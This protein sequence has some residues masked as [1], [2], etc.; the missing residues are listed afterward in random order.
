ML[1]PLRIAPLAA[2]AFALALAPSHAPEP[3]APDGFQVK[4]ELRPA[5]GAH[6][7]HLR[8]ATPAGEPWSVHVL[9]VRHDAKV[10]IVAMSG[11][12]RNGRMARV[13]PTRIAE[14]VGGAAVV[15][16]DYDLPEPNLG[17][18]DGLSVTSG[19][20]WTTGKPGW[21]AMAILTSGEPAIGYPRVQVTLAVGDEKIEISALNKPFGALWG[22][23]LRLFTREFRDRL[24][25]PAP[26]RAVVIENLSPAL[27]LRVDSTVRGRIRRVVTSADVSVPEGALVVAE[28]AGSNRLAALARGQRVQIEI[29]AEINGRAGIREAIGGYPI[30]VRDGRPGVE[31]SPGE[32]LRRRHPRTASCY[33]DASV[34]F[35]VVDGRQPELSVGMTLE[36]LGE[37]MAGLGCEI[38]LNTDG[39]GSSVMGVRTP[40]DRMGGGGQMVI[41]N[42]PSD[43]PERGRGNAWVVI[44][45]PLPRRLPQD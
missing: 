40:R 33:N 28:P 45:P 3:Q 10:S 14:L 38:A 22:E 17:I 21:P 8:G 11:V 36:E 4:S 18:P 25:A 30:V 24:R 16:G 27:P 1:R 37:L 32:Y 41:V 2:L 19:R 44:A 9:K 31:D 5:E 26:M 23:G 43:G 6:Y 35:A 7:T 13:L 15:N 29:R 39:G 20:I 42:S 12:D 34:L